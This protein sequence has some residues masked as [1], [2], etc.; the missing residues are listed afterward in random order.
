VCYSD[1]SPLLVPLS[2]SSSPSPP[3]LPLQSPT[4]WTDCSVKCG[5]GIQTRT[6]PCLHSTRV[7]EG[8]SNRYTFSEV[9]SYVCLG[10][11]PVPSIA[12]P[13]ATIPC[14][15][16]A[17]DLAMWD[18][19]TLT[20]GIPRT[21]LLPAAGSTVY[22]Y[23]RPN[24]A[25]RG[26]CIKV[27]AT[28]PTSKVCTVSAERRL[29]SC[30]NGLS[31]C[32]KVARTA[33]ADGGDPTEYTRM[34]EWLWE[35]A[36]TVDSPPGT[37][38]CFETVRT[39]LSGDVCSTSVDSM[40]LKVARAC[41]KTA[42][43][44]GARIGGGSGSPLICSVAEAVVDT[45]PGILE[46]YVAPHATSDPTLQAFAA[47]LTAAG[48]V[49]NSRAGVGRGGQF[50]M[51]YGDT[52][53]YTSSAADTITIGLTAPNASV[54]ATITATA[55]TSFPIS[56][57]GSL[58][59]GVSA[60][61]IRA[62]GATLT[63]DSACD[64]FTTPLESL[65]RAP[66]A[67]NLSAGGGMNLLA[68][69]FLPSSS[70]SSGWLREVRPLL[71]ASSTAPFVAASFG[72]S[73]L[74]VTLPPVPAYNPTQ[75][76]EIT[77]IIPGSLLRSGRA[78]PV[79]GLKIRIAAD[80]QDCTVGAWS[81]WSTCSASCAPGLQTRT[82]DI[83]R[84][85]A[86]AGAAC[87]ATLQTR[88]CNDCDP[89]TT[90]ACQN[91]GVC[92]L[93]V[94]SCPPGYAGSDC[95]VPPARA[96]VAFWRVGSWGDCTRNCAGGTQEREVVCMVLSAGVAVAAAS[97]SVCA[98][99]ASPARTQPCMQQACD[100]PVLRLSL[101]LNVSLLPRAV[102]ADMASSMVSA[103]VSELASALSVSP[104]RISVTGLLPSTMTADGTNLRTQD[105][106]LRDSTVVVQPGRD[107]T[108][109]SVPGGRRLTGNATTTTTTTTTTSAT[110]P[111]TVNGTVIRL[112]IL[113]PSA[114]S[115]NASTAAAATAPAGASTEVV[116]TQLQ[117]QA[118]STTSS[119]ATRGTYLPTAVWTSSQFNLVSGIRAD[120]VSASSSGTL[121]TTPTLT[122]TNTTTTTGTAGSGAGAGSGSTNAGT[123][124]GN[125]TGTG[126]GAGTGTGTGA[127]TGTGTGTG[128]GTGTSTGTGGV[129][130]SVG[131]AGGGGATD[132]LSVA[133]MAVIATLLVAV[134]LG[135]IAGIVCLIRHTRAAN[136]SKSV[137]A[138]SLPT[139]FSQGPAAAVSATPVGGTGA[140]VSANPLAGSSSGAIDTSR[141]SKQT[142]IPG[143]PLPPR[144]G[145]G[146]M[147][148]NPAR[149]SIGP[150]PRR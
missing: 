42:A 86:G 44:N 17:Y 49:W 133:V 106:S 10:Y 46:V 146:F 119:I 148:E 87:P 18:S 125:S 33:A 14:T 24:A 32:L 34:E 81:V 5:G 54:T 121:A 51:I 85:R 53:G 45:S 147:V 52:D 13:C 118:G 89:C 12:A 39:C 55:L 37:C 76:E 132:S 72:N 126:A 26:V 83:V 28:A 57:S 77:L 41:N 149:L 123:G 91:G 21:D 2:P 140:W 9:P 107:Y 1:N 20:T 141:S 8:A 60:A 29:A 68:A 66:Y 97:E 113:P 95:S 80:T 136:L 137:A 15:N 62:G 129:S 27:E 70:S 43:C 100:E 130:I 3:P 124:T 112:A 7:S 48:T 74:R 22:T 143:L 69:G 67:A 63:L 23:Q 108:G 61:A 116:L 144:A 38:G 105:V 90:V 4:P 103:I 64:L 139:V 138:G 75:D 128:A 82:R 40:R 93:G 59:A 84:Y 56:P 31:T 131:T 58:V 145:G 109:S 35:G 102:S 47:P 94:C 73:R 134:V 30:L 50:L 150:T 114:A 142:R 96:E 88:K 98:G 99:V 36:G 117:Q 25:S 127:G 101:A 104:G 11:A 111:T 115:L 135:L 16:L 71:L 122:T 6:T 79:E 92:A 120:P 65:A 78:T 110:T 19:R